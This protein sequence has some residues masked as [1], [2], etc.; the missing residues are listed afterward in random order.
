MGLAYWHTND[1]KYAREWCY[2]P[3]ATLSARKKK[4]VR[5]VT[6]VTPYNESQPKINVR[7]IGRPRIGAS[8][9]EL[10][11][12]NDGIQKRIGYDL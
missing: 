5:F 2:Q 4:G 7:I 6:V 11:V 12:E 9:I 10:E 8:H 3:F 1:E